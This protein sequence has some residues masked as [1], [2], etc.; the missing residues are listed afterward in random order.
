MDEPFDP[1][2]P[3]TSEE[4]WQTALKPVPA[5]KPQSKS[6]VVVAPHPDDET[7]G[8]GGLMFMCAQAQCEIIVVLATDG[9][10]ARRDLPNLAELRV[11]ELKAAMSWIAPQGFRLLRAQLPDGDVKSHANELATLLETVTPYNA[12]LV[13]PFEEDGH[14]DHNAVGMAC[15]RAARKLNV[16][17]VR[18][19]VWAWHRQ[20]AD[21]FKSRKLGRFK[22]T[23]QA[24]M[25]K[26]RAI[27]CYASQLEE[28][29]EGAV[30]P[31]HVLEY[32]RRPYEVFLV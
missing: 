16:P 14:T 6:L 22:L 3:G 18:Y 25:A 1:Q 23:S 32:F 29:P 15:F 5:W 9:E 20:P 13:G 2:Q 12:T 8:A 31:A 27:D 26:A 7:L 21:A 30:M 17:L 19:P 10:A 4:S 11:A 24:L 28:R